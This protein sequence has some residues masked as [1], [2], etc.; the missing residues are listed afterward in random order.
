MYRGG[1]FGG[2]SY[3]DPPVPALPAPCPDVQS[4]R[5]CFR[6]KPG[7]MIIGSWVS[8][9]ERFKTLKGWLE[10]SRVDPILLAIMAFGLGY[11]G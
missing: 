5:A 10:S 6:A 2:T 8:W 4:A 3:Y 11:S 9:G 7:F 1:S